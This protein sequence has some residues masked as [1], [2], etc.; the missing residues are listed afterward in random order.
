MSL[1]GYKYIIRRGKTKSRATSRPN[2][3]S[4]NKSGGEE[5]CGCGLVNERDDD[6]DDARA[7][8]F[9]RGG[10][11]LAFIMMAEKT[12]ALDMSALP[13]AE[14]YIPDL[15]D[16]VMN[17]ANITI[18]SAYKYPIVQCYCDAGIVFELKKYATLLDGIERDIAEHY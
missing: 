16:L 8:D 10:R 15:V 6:A 5:D 12:F 4:G 18:P 17:A 2:R 11:V 9:V 7:D 3:A 14:G 13:F 1:S